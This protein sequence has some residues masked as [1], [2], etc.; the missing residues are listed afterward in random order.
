M[1]KNTQIEANTKRLQKVT[2]F[3]KIKDIDQVVQPPI[4]Q[5]IFTRLKNNI[6]KQRMLNNLTQK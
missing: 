4:N 2:V 1:N 3:E 5:T 6:K